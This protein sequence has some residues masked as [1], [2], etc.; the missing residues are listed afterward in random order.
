ME[1]RLEVALLC[2]KPPSLHLQIVLQCIFMLTRPLTLNTFDWSRAKQNLTVSRG[3]SLQV[4]GYIAGN[5]EA[6]K[7][8]NRTVTAVVT[9]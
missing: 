3:T 8:L 5:F 7:S 9:L 1:V 6:G 2:Y 4:I